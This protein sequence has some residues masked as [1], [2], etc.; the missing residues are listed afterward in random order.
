MSRAVFNTGGRLVNRVVLCQ[1]C[2]IHK[3]LFIDKYCIK[4][5][6]AVKDGAPKAL[7]NKSYRAGKTAQGIG[8]KRL[9]YGSGAVKDVESVEAPPNAEN[10]QFEQLTLLETERETAWSAVERFMQGVK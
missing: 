2:G 7:E 6:I 9:D 1:R 8:L 5:S 4:C 10:A 3:K